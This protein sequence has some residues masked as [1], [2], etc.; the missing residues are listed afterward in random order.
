MD[1]DEKIIAG[2]RLAEGRAK[3]Y[4]LKLAAEQE[5]AL[6]EGITVEALRKLKVR[7]RR[8]KKYQENKEKGAAKQKPFT[9][10]SRSQTHT[11]PAEQKVQEARELADKLLPAQKSSWTATDKMRA[12]DLYIVGHTM[13]EIASLIGHSVKEVRKHIN[14][15][16]RS[17][18]Q[19]KVTRMLPQMVKK[20][21]TAVSHTPAHTAEFNNLLNP[22]L[23]NVEFFS[24]LSP[25]DAEE[26]TESEV[27][28]CW[29]YVSSMDLEEAIF[30]SGLDAGLYE[31][32]KTAENGAPLAIKGFEACV[33]MRIA[34][35]KMKPNIA[36]FIK[37]IRAEAVFN[38][39]VDKDFLQ[40]EIMCQIEGLK[41]SHSMEAKKLLR[42]YILMLGRTFGG[43]VDKV[44]VEEVDHAKTIEKLMKAAK[45]TGSGRLVA[46]AARAKAALEEEE[47]MR[48][49]EDF[50]E[51]R[52]VH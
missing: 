1:D 41:L 46:E 42:D 33:K 27:K 18:T 43:F 47:R 4:A 6:K 40:K 12:L 3:K 52:E 11:R 10:G 28:F 31:I 7:E 19:A 22:E 14:T 39:G 38:V 23:I 25:P 5:E 51:N 32:H 36:A 49:L 17:I 8:M 2:K 35:L 26:L 37:K 24:R 13:E 15:Y 44:E 34:F 16:Q 48:T 30:A 50:E 45:K 29:A 20:D 21:G 9:P